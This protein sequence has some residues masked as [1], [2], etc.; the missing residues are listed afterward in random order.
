MLVIL[1]GVV[2]TKGKLHLSLGAMV[3][4][5]RGNMHE[6]HL[7]IV[8]WVGWMVY[9]GIGAILWCSTLYSSAAQWCTMVI[10]GV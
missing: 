3:P 8:Q 2:C 10:S 4:L 1:L 9:T 6:W 7:C 5:V